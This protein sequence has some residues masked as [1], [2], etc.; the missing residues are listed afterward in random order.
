MTRR[1]RRGLRG[2]FDVLDLDGD[3]GMEALRAVCPS[4]PPSTRGRWRTG[5]EGCICPPPPAS[6][7]G[8][9]SCPGWTG[10]AGA[11]IVAPPS[12]HASGTCYAWARPLT[13]ASPEVPAGL[14]RLPPPGRGERWI[15]AGLVVEVLMVERRDAHCLP[16]VPVAECAASCAIEPALVFPCF[17]IHPRGLV[18]APSG[19]QRTGVPRRFVVSQERTRGK[20]IGPCR[21]G[22]AWI[23]CCRLGRAAGTSWRRHSGRISA[24]EIQQRLRC[25]APLSLLAEMVRSASNCRSAEKGSS[26]GNQDDHDVRL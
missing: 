17:A 6:A 25:A 26:G 7:T 18:R 3:Q 21:S 9:S 22:S 4:L 15:L 20:A 11:L 23:P 2:R 1:R 13:A 12:Q 19:E 8:S 14:R 5:G 10:G 24:K 16:L